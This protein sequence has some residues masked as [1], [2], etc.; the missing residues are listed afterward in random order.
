MFKRI[1]F[2]FFGVISLLSTTHARVYLT[3]GFNGAEASW[4]QPG[5][6][7]HEA[8]K[9]TAAFNGHSIEHFSWEQKYLGFFNSEHALAGLSLATKIIKFCHTY[10][11]NP[12]YPND[13]KIV[14]VAHSYGGLVSYNASEV[15]ARFLQEIENEETKKY[16]GLMGWLRKS[17]SKIAQV[18]TSSMPRPVISKLCTLGTPH[19]ESDV[20]PNPKGVESIYNLFSLADWVAYEPVAG[21]PYLPESLLSQHPLAHNVQLFGS[22]HYIVH[23][24]AHSEIHHPAVA[25]NIF[26]IMNEADQAA[27]QI[28]APKSIPYTV[29]IP[30]SIEIGT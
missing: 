12:K 23:G 7:F 21:K 8:L 15:L 17:W 30:E 22:S 19:R 16:Q 28:P 14:V 29:I 13:D 4:Y 2:L 1:I 27:L 11:Y 25:E 20:T 10:K 9:K 26:D 6:D 18:W 24:F 3:H 5:G